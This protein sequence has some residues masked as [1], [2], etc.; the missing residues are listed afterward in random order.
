MIQ[1]I[2]SP[3]KLLF[4]YI[5]NVTSMISL[6]L[7]LIAVFLILRFLPCAATNYKIV[8]VIM[9]IMAT[10]N[11]IYLQ[12]LMD[13]IV[14]FPLP[15]FYIDGILEQWMHLPA[16]SSLAVCPILCDVLSSIFQTLPSYWPDNI[17]SRCDCV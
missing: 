5:Q 9:T 15:C 10:A 11:D 6:V 17:R 14:L 8:L 2:S 13:P 7:S 1:P 4:S 12:I 3:S 16:S